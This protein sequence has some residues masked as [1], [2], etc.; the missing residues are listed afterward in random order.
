MTRRSVSFGADRALRAASNADGW[1]GCGE[2]QL[3]GNL[4]GAL[5]H[6]IN[7]VDAGHPIT[8]DRKVL[9]E[10]AQLDG[11]EPLTRCER[12]RSVQVG[13][14]NGQRGGTGRWQVSVG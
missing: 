14:R 7:R 13:E 4:F 12:H 1:T 6:R 9:A 8:V 10:H 5:G 3:D 2:L 11:G